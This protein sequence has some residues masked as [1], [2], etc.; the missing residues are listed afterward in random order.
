MQHR[1]R[2]VEIDRIHPDNARTIF[3]APVMCKDK[4]SISFC[5]RFKNNGMGKY[6]CSDAEFAIRVCRQSCGYCNDDLYSFHK[7]TAPCK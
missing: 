1:F 2:V 5:R 4:H 3:K 7:A 6:S